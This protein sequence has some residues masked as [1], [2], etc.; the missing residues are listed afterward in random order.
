MGA[1]SGETFLFSIEEPRSAAVLLFA[2]ILPSS[3]LGRGGGENVF[4]RGD[5]GASGRDGGDIISDLPPFNTRFGG[6][7]PIG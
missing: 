2:G 3:K 4:E 5:L 6:A 7:A 1:G